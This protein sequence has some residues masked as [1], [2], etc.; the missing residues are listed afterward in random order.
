V[1]RADFLV[2][3]FHSNS[4]HFGFYVERLEMEKPSRRRLPQAEQ[5]MRNKAAQDGT[6]LL[7]EKS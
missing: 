5:A 1:D 7:A 3:E 6:A 2:T 4:F